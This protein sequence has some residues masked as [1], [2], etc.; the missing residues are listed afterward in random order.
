[1]NKNIL[2]NL[3][4]EDGIYSYIFKNTEQKLEVET[5]KNFANG[6]VN[7][8]YLNILSKH[9]SIEVM[10]K[11]VVAF[12][13]SIP[14]NGSIIDVG[15]CWGWHWRNLK[16][17]RP[18]VKV[19]IVDLVREN[20]Y[21]AKQLLK[22]DINDNVYLVHGD[23]TDL[24]FNCNVF[25][26][27]WS[28]Q[29]LQHIPNF[30]KAIEEGYRVLKNE[31]VF[32]SYSLN[33]QSIIRFI[34]QIFGKKYLTKGSNDFFYLERASKN[35]KDIIKKIFNNNVSQ[36]YSEVLFKPELGVS[37]AGQENSFFGVLDSYLSNGFGLW[38][39]IAR[40]ESYHVKK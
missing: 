1:M 28:V 26:G 17:M 13:K 29:T 14:K 34:Y 19:F 25:D 40:Q 12:L 20:L 35:Q 38:S 7:D 11:E 36:R 3:T 8:S 10:D 22:T 23:A 37:L 21:H 18:D 6:V 27:Y 9:H 33:N 5:R 31:G 16:E 4:L 24:V 32:A 30:S 39:S 2:N 15:G